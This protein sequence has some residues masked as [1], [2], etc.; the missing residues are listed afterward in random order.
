MPGMSWNQTPQSILQLSRYRSIAPSSTRRYCSTTS[1]S[2]KGWQTWSLSRELRWFQRLQP[3]RLMILTCGKTKASLAY[4]CIL[5]HYKRGQ[6]SMATSVHNH[7]SRYLGIWFIATA[8][9]LGKDSDYGGL[10]RRV[11]RLSL[12]SN[13]V[14]W[15]DNILLPREQ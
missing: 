12:G 2:F 11:T 7:C 3:S 8:V 9:Y 4:K 14:L 5:V 1:P 15:E 6:L 10:L 13:L